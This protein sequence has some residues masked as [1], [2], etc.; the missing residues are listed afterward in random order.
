MSN[1][2]CGDSLKS[3]WKLTL[4]PDSTHQNQRKATSALGLALFN[5]Y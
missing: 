5:L 4:A 3:P 1:L 2:P